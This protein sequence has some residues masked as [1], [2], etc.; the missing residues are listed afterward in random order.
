MAAQPAPSSRPPRLDETYFHASLAEWAEWKWQMAHRIVGGSDLEGLPGLRPE[1]ITSMQQVSQQYPFAV[2]P[3]FLSLIDGSNAEDPLRKQVLPGPEEISPQEDN[4]LDP[5]AEEEHTMAPGLVHR[6]PNRVVLLTTNRCAVY[7]RYCFRKRLWAQ[8]FPMEI[9]GRW[10]EAISYLRFHTEIH[11]V[12]LSGGDPLTLGNARLDEILGNLRNI[13]HIE[14]IRIGTRIPVVLP[15]RITPDLCRVL[16]RHGPIWLVTQFNHPR[17]IT[18]ETHA[19]CERLL[20]SGLPV[21]SQS[22]LLRGVN[23]TPETMRA[24]CQDLLRIRVR[25]Y[26]LH[27]CDRVAGAGHFRTPLQRGIEIVEQMQGL[28]SGLAMPKFVVDLPGRGGKVPLQTDYCL[29]DEDNRT[30]LRNYAGEIFTY[31]DPS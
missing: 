27:Q 2:T 10:E 19:A 28:T 6:Y 7:C 31:D 16:D 23:D 29:S 24:L 9:Q 30:V 21:N 18:R 1:E 15:Q 4:P 8:E 5:L 12:L 25:P 14:I 11:E 22:V 3:Y 20:R 26:Y 13:P 17:E